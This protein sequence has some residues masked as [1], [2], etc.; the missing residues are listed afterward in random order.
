MSPDLIP[1][2]VLLAPDVP[3]NGQ[4]PHPD[5]SLGGIPMP[6]RLTL[7]RHAALAGDVRNNAP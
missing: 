5:K 2:Y 4:A 7:K 6:K 3:S 1:R